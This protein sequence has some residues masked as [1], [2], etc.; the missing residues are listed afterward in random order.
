MITGPFFGPNSISIG[1]NRVRVPTHI[2]K[3]VYD[4]ETKRAWAHWQENASG[5]RAGEPISYDE[6][7]KR[8]GMEL[9]PGVTPAPRLPRWDQHQ[10]GFLEQ[11]ADGASVTLIEN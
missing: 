2:F 1:A 7:T 10:A 9:L 6:L 11:R 5:V 3:L 4:A 8:V